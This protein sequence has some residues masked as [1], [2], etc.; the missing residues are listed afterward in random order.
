M[1][2]GND[3]FFAKVASIDPLARTLHLPG[4]NKYAQGVAQRNA[5]ATDVNGGPFTGIAPTL[6]AANGGYTAGATGAPA[7]W[8]QIN[9]GSNPSGLFGDALKINN[10]V[11]NVSP[12]LNA[13]KP[14][15]FS[16][17]NPAVAGPGNGG[18]LPPSSAYVNAARGATQNTWG[19]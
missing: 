4:S 14:A 5:G 11:A 7:N 10:N 18:T 15:P 16:F 1:G 8:Q 3:S 12:G 9:L 17:S 13:Q 6:A 19:G 2:A